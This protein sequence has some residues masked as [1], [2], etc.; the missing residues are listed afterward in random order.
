MV[1]ALDERVSCGITAGSGSHV[2]ID[3]FRASDPPERRR[4]R[5]F[6]EYGVVRGNSGSLVVLILGPGGQEEHSH[7]QEHVGAVLDGEFVI[8]VSGR[9]TVVRSGELYRVPAHEPHGIRCHER[10][11]VVQVRGDV[12]RPNGAN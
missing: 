10:A 9:E 3:V 8:T 12:R 2:P 11:V 5:D 4:Q 1:E 6:V 7:E